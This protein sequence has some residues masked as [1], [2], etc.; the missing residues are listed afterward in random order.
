MVVRLWFV[1]GGAVP[2]PMYM[3]PREKKKERW[4][5]IKRSW[6]RKKKDGWNREIVGN[7][8]VQGGLEW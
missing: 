7:R 6:K 8:E 3:Y 5:E 2:F 1:E 4:L